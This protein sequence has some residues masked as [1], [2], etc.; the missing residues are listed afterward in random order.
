MDREPVSKSTIILNK[1]ASLKEVAEEKLHRFLPRKGFKP[2]VWTMV[3]GS[4]FVCSF[5]LLRMVES[6]SG[7]QSA[8]RRL[9]A[10]ESALKSL[11][12]DSEYIHGVS[13]DYATWEVSY[14]AKRFMIERWK[15]SC[16][17]PIHPVY[18]LK[19][20]MKPDDLR[21]RGCERRL[22]NVIIA[23]VRKCGTG[24][25]L[26]FLNF[27]PQLVG[28]KDETHYFDSQNEHGLDWYKNQMP[29][30]S[31][32]QVTI[33]KTPTYFFRPFDAPKRIRET[34]SPNVRILVIVCEPVRRL[35]SDYVE[36]INKTSKPTQDY[37]QRK[38]LGETIEDTVFEKARPDN[39]NMY[40][41]MVDV[42]LY[43]KYLFRWLEFFPKNQIHF[44]DGDNFRR[45]PAVE[46]QKVEKFIGVR[47]YFREEHFYYDDEKRYY[48]IS[49]P[50]ITCMPSSKGREHPELAD[51]AKLRLC[52]FYRPYDYA[53]SNILKY[54]FT[55][56]GKNC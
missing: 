30:S 24:T 4:I 17:Y 42:G 47:G 14:D 28:P 22:P 49:F 51:W 38:T 50:K 2:S 16:Y 25:L 12:N 15:T 21:R 9:L 13:D 19:K 35:V 54:N 55:W 44:I 46:L 18:R 36:F 37:M 31:R 11:L 39:V 32:Y 34:L 43:V 40:N 33:E 20:L 23:G 26:K 53:L 1:M 41:E 10:E 6:P 5:L 27:H 7:G 48:C 52:E 8:S 45:S 3:Y 29:Y 56:L